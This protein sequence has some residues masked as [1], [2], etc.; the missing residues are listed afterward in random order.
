MATIQTGDKMSTYTQDI[1]TET[2]QFSYEI[3]FAPKGMHVPKT[4]LLSGRGADDVILQ[5]V[6]QFPA[7]KGKV[8][9]VKQ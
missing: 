8:K 4:G 2:Y 3:T 6:N 7:C 5:L 9:R 1:H